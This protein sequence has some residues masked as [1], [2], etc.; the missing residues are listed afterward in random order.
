M[1]EEGGG[2]R[3]GGRGAIILRKYAGGRGVNEKRRGAYKGG[4][5]ILNWRFYCVRTLWMPP[6]AVNFFHDFI[7]FSLRETRRKEKL[8]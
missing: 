7:T 3:K 4:G 8:I 2:G 6:K 5:G 1:G